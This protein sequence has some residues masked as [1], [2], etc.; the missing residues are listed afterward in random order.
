M[1]AIQNHV[2]CGMLVVG[3]DVSAFTRVWGIGAP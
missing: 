2:P 1:N 3:G